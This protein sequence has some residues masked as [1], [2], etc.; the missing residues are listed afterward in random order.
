MSTVMAL[1]LFKIC[2]V[3]SRHPPA[4]ERIVKEG[5]ILEAPV[6]YAV[7]SAFNN[8]GGKEYIYTIHTFLVWAHPS[9]S[10][11]LNNRVP[12]FIMWVSILNS[13]LQGFLH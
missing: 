8:L 6:A 1:I 7:F 12:W 9:Q 4:P 3:S 10:F 2:V 11:R 5:L 13:D